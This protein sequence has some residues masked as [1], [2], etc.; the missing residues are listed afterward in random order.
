MHSV[1]SYV[2]FGPAEAIK[3][4]L[5]ESRERKKK[6]T[7]AQ[8]LRKFI[9]RNKNKINKEQKSEEDEKYMQQDALDSMA[10]S[11][12]R[13]K[14]YKSF[15]LFPRQAKEWAGNIGG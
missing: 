14:T 10:F 4:R 8:K 1:T 5:P 12:Q 6:P 15:R 9:P 3:T 7:A 11:M 13:S 2:Q